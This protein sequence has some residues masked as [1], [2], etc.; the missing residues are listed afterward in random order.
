MSDWWSK[1]LG[2]P[3]SAPPASHPP[4]GHRPIVGY[5]Q[6][7]QQQVAQPQQQQ[8]VVQQQG[9][10]PPGVDPSQWNQGPKMSDML[11]VDPVEV[12]AQAKGM[13][14]ETDLCPQCGGGNYFSR[15]NGVLRGHAPMPHCYDCG[16]PIEQAGSPG[17]P[18]TAMKPTGAPRMAA[19]PAHYSQQ[20]GA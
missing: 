5:Q 10:V 8:Q 3:V 6:Q 14:T 15:S 11:L 1:K 9:P 17:G 4:T 13:L 18:A 2:G 19:Q 16:F 20:L 12:P 7:Q